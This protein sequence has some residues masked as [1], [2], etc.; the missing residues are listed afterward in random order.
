[1]EESQW[2]RLYR[3][4]DKG[5]VP[6]CQEYAEVCFVPEELARK[7]DGPVFRYLA[8]REVLEQPALP[9][10]DGQLSLPFPT[11]D[12]GSVKH[13]VFGIV[14]NRD[15]PGDELI[16]WYRQRCGKSEEAH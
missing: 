1:M 13:K 2:C 12:F 6:T 7:K 8:I 3:K 10:M 5:M 11:M 15:L 4:T 9:E 14:T 16:W